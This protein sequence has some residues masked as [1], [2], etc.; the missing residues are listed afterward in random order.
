MHRESFLV[1]HNVDWLTWAERY[2]LEPARIPCKM[3]GSEF[4]TNIPIANKEFRGLLSEQCSCGNTDTPYCFVRDPQIG[5]L[6]T[7][8]VSKKNS[9]K[10]VSPKKI[11]RV[12]LLLRQPGNFCG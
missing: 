7:T 3:C 6:L 10:K 11:D 8:D 9:K 5:D 2:G 12:V 4:I 1:I